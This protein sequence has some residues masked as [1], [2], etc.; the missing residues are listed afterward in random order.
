MAGIARI[1]APTDFSA[2]ADRA[3]RR[4]A[5]LAST[6]TGVLHLAHVLPPQDVLQQIFPGSLQQEADALRS[7]AERALQ[8]RADLITSRFGIA[9]VCEVLQGHAHEAI[10][11]ASESLGATIVVV[12]AQGEHERGAAAETVGGTAFEIAGRSRVPTLLVR[13]EV[14]EPYRHVVGC[15]KGTVA[16]RGVLEWADRVSPDHLI[17]ILSAY[18]VPY[19]ERLIQWG[20]SQSTLDV[21]ATRER[22]ERTRRLSEL[23]EQFGL[24]AARARLHIE[25]G[26]PLEKIL[27]YAAQWKADLIIVG[28][29]A[30]GRAPLFGSIARRVAVHAPTD[31]MIASPGTN[32]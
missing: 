7:R 15:A 3:A 5:S 13:S 9:P 18:T 24:P 21:Y 14:Q 31:V 29:R 16:D 28:R 22:E 1:I 32:A 10:L 8:E 30:Q 25:R 11:D 17:H 23:L 27:N 4:A 19:E 20:A 12:G 6:L 2:A 26:E